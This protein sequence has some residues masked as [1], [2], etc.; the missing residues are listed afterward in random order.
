VSYRADGRDL[1][2]GVGRYRFRSPTAPIDRFV[3]ALGAVAFVVNLIALFGTMYV[4]DGSGALVDGSATVARI[5]HW[6][7]LRGWQLLA[8]LGAFSALVAPSFAAARRVRQVSSLFTL[9]V[10]LTGLVAWWW[11]EIGTLLGQTY[12]ETGH[13][14]LRGGIVFS[15][16][17]LGLQIAVGAL[18]FMSAF[19]LSAEASAHQTEIDRQMSGPGV[20]SRL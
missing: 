16:I 17:A 18:M 1:E 5:Q 10:A 15:G 12:R 2:R 6:R 7:E 19:A 13:V 9:G 14:A 11:T 8:L 4:S 20:P 3:I